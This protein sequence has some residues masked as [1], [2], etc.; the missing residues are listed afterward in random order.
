M[1]LLL[2]EVNGIEEYRVIGAVKNGIIRKPIGTCAKMFTTE[3]QFGHAGTMAN[4]V[5]ETADATMRQAE[6]VVSVTFGDTRSRVSIIP[7]FV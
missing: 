7:I 1:L 6:F 5:R 2:G 4:S 3:V